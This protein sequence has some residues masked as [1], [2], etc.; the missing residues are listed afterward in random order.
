MKRIEVFVIVLLLG[1][2]FSGINA[3]TLSGR[4]IIQKAKDRPDGD[5]RYMEMTME[6]INK[7]GRKRERTVRSFS[8]DIGKDKKTIMFFISW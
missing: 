3:Q 1:M 7:R 8:I 6:L 4:D 5:T 2:F